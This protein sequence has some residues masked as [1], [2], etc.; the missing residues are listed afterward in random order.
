[1]TKNKPFYGWAIVGVGALVAFSS[2]PGQSFIFSV[3]IDDLIEDT[4]LSRTAISSLYAIGTGLSAF[5][6]FTVSRLADRY[7]AR[8]TLLAAATGL[9]LACLAM[10]Q[11]RGALAV[12]IAFSALRALGQGSMS[13]NATLL[14]AQWFIRKRGRAMAIMSLGFTLG[15]AILPPVCRAL[16][17]NI[18]WRETYIVLGLMVWLLVLPTAIFVVR[19]RPEDIGLHPDGDTQPP[20]EPARRAAVRAAGADRGVLLSPRFWMLALPLAVPGMVGTG[21]VFHQ[22][23]ILEE[24]GLS[25]SIAAATFLAV[26]GS[27]AVTALFAGWLADRTTPKA[28][29]V[30]ALSALLGAILFLPLVD[31][32]AMVTIYG[33]F[34]G[35]TQG[36]GGL[37]NNV[38]WAHF[39]GREGLGRVQGSGVTVGITGS[40]LGPLPLSWLASQTGSFQE[41]ALI[42]GF[43]PLL[44]IGAIIL[45]K[46]PTG[47]EAPSREPAAV[48]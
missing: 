17:D 38:I 34:M 45:A 35:I 1:M 24:R 7:G 30:M 39:Y 9:G 13:I 16:I 5:M 19:N 12:F 3:F 37:V 48:A 4:G 21:L 42:M 46:P 47:A 6:V 22:T 44:A 23:A 14:T 25:A 33:I 10:S 43:L 2:S 36:A 15:L 32:V 27:A 31:S 41:A 8:T 11:A 29:L 18:G 40:A 26:A 28:V 20:A